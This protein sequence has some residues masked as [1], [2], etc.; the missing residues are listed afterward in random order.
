MRET[1]TRKLA[2]RIDAVLCLTNQPFLCRGTVRRGGERGRILEF[3]Q[4][5]YE[6]EHMLLHIFRLEAEASAERPAEKSLQAQEPRGLPK[7]G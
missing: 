1:Y 4:F 3:V 7:T 2:E 6:L 5:A